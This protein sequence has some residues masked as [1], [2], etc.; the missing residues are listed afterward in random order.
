M[1]EHEFALDAKELGVVEA[2]CAKCGA[3]VV[4]DC[5]N[6]LQNPPS[7][8]PSCATDDS[9]MYQW[10]MVYRRWY[11]SINGSKKRFRFRVPAK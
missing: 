5:A 1:G 7:R 10:L 11:L 2:S 8:C 3:G 4:F 9:E 6:E